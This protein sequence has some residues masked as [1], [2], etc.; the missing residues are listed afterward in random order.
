MPAEKSTTTGNSMNAAR[1]A[2]DLIRRYGQRGNARMLVVG[3]NPAE[4]VSCLRA[5]GVMAFGLFDGPAPPRDP[6]LRPAD[7]EVVPEVQPA[8]LHQ[9]VPF[10]AQS[11]DCVLLGESDVYKGSLTCPE[12]CTATANLLACLKPGRS[13]VC[14]GPVATAAYDRHLSVFP[15]RSRTIALGTGGI[16]GVL[17]RLIGQ[18]NAQPGIQFTIPDDAISRLEWHRLARQAV[19]ASQA[20]QQQPAA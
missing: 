2:K 1:L 14:C 20:C 9:S 13:L 16:V 10:L 7:Q 17:Q 15:G 3:S 18:G 5:G 12:A 4:L 6:Y 11:F 8:V 19:M